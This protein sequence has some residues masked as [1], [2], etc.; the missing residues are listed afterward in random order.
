LY[1]VSQGR[2]SRSAVITVNH[3]IYLTAVKIETMT[4]RLIN[5]SFEDTG[6]EVEED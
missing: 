4:N 5:D 2:K 6:D 1:D 3:Q